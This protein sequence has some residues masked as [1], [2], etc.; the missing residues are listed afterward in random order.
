MCT[1]S[2]Q[3]PRVAVSASTAGGRLGGGLAM[4]AVRRACVRVS[5]GAGVA[6]GGG[7]GVPVLPE[8]ASCQ[9]TTPAIRTAPTATPTRV[10]DR[11]P[12]RRTSSPCGGGGGLGGSGG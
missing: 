5:V 3:L 8:P 2:Q 6:R 10:G 4:V 12:S 1:D 11:S 9:T 7:F